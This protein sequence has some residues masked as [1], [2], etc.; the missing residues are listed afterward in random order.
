[1]ASRAR[2]SQRSAARLWWRAG[3]ALVHCP[4]SKKRGGMERWTALARLT[5][6][7]GGPPRGRADLRKSGRRSPAIRGRRAF[8]RS[9]AAFSL[10][11]W[12]ALSETFAPSISQLLAGGRCTSGQSPNA[13]RVRALRRLARGRRA[14]EG[15]ELPGARHRRTAPVLRRILR[16]VPPSRRLMRAPLSERGEVENRTEEDQSQGLGLKYST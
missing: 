13:A 2:L 7:P 4:S 10:L 14:G 6:A 16:F 15:P 1:M 9:I 5:D 12:A 8:R 3:C 11:R